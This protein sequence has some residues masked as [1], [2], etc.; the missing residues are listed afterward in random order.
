MDWLFYRS[1]IAANLSFLALSGRRAISSLDLFAPFVLLYQCT[2]SLR[3]YVVD[4]SFFPPPL[5]RVASNA[6][7]NTRRERRRFHFGLPLLFLLP[8]ASSRTA[9]GLVSVR[10]SPSEVLPPRC[11]SDERSSLLRGFGSFVAG[12]CRW[13]RDHDTYAENA[14]GPTTPDSPSLFR[15]AGNSKLYASW[16]LYVKRL[17]LISLDRASQEQFKNFVVHSFIY[18]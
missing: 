17:L 8:A 2:F 18:L 3:F 14:K 9:L 11:L 5:G 13:R 16:T 6:S 7:R 15:V 1:S 4:K 12:A 10:A